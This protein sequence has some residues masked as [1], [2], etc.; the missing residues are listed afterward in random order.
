M[1]DVVS[2][3]RYEPNV[4]SITTNPVLKE[5]IKVRFRTFR[6]TLQRC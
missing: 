2:L 4:L 3:S 5:P 1:S 6:L